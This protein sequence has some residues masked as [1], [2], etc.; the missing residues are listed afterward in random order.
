MTEIIKDT[1]V[2]DT[3]NQ[4][5]SDIKTL[6]QRQGGLSSLN[7][8]AKNSLV[9]AINEVL[10]KVNTKSS[11]SISDNATENDSTWS[12][13]KIF[14]AI[15]E[16]QINAVSQAKSQLLNGAGAALDTLK[17]LADAI[18]NDPTFASTLANQLNSRLRFDEEQV[19]TTEQKKLGCRNLGLPSPTTD[20]LALYLAAR[21]SL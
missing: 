10:T 13:H 18:N 20:Y 17:E 7:T 19:L 16:A 9:G 1:A 8:T 2:L 5:A 14:Q 12:S 21:G 11:V 4:I 6:S 15:S 3:F